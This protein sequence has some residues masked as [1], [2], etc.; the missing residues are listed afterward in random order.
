M[1]NGKEMN[2]VIIDECMDMP[3]PCQHCGGWFDLNDGYGSEKWHK[4]ITICPTCYAEE[5]KEIELDE[6]I[7]V[8]REEIAEAKY[9]LK[10]SRARLLALGL[11]IDLNDE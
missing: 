11:P 7:E 6:E 2:H 4:D 1:S 8:L 9:T 5:E 10:H 3:T